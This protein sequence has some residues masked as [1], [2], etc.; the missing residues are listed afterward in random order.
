MRRFE[1]LLPSAPV[2]GR[3]S[4]PHVRFPALGGLWRQGWAWFGVAVLV[5]IMGLVAWV[6]TD[7]R[8]FIYAEDVHFN[9]LHYLAPEELFAASQMNGWNVFWIDSNQVGRQI[10]SNPYVTSAAVH[11]DLIGGKVT[12]DIVEA[13]PVAWWVTDMGRRWLLDS[14]IALEP[15]GDSPPGLMEILDK[16]AEATAPGAPLGAAVDPDVLVSAQALV[17]R[18]PGVAPLRYQ[19]DIGLN[20]LLPGT[21]YWVYWGDGAN[22]ERKLEYL[23]AGERLLDEGKLEG[24]VIDVRFDPPYVK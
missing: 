22:A 6:H 24:N 19:R 18:L 7:D 23:A 17:N 15:R 9:G 4:L 10:L 16:P 3:L 14:G 8:W 20:F 1:V 11:R 12:V 2:T 5:A 13:R 21:Q